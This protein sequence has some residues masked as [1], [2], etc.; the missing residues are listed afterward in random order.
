M[1]LQALMAQSK[2]VAIRRGNYC[3]CWRSAARLCSADL[4]CR[5]IE[6]KAPHPKRPFEIIEADID[7]ALRVVPILRNDVGPRACQ[8]RHGHLADAKIPILDAGA[9]AAHVQG[10]EII[11][12]D[13]L[14]A[15]IA[16]TGP[17]LRIRLALQDV[18]A[19]DKGF[20]QGELIIPH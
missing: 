9:I 20:P 4:R 15:V 13:V 6:P 16:F 18:A 2:R 17:E 12:L 14:A 7:I 8:I 10:I 1:P 3:S 19:P 11:N 5:E